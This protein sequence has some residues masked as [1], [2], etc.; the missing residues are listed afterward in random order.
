MNNKQGFDTGKKNV[1]ANTQNFK[2]HVKALWTGTGVCFQD[3]SALM[4]F[5]LHSL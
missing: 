5:P 2:H 4:I 3:D 1:L